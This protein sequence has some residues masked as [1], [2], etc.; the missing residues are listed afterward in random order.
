MRE[1]RWILAHGLRLET[2]RKCMVQEH[3]A[4]GL[5]VPCQEAVKEENC[6]LACFYVFIKYWTPVQRI[7]LHLNAIGNTIKDMPKALFEEILNPVLLG[8]TI[9]HKEPSWLKRGGHCENHSTHNHI[10]SCGRHHKME[11]RNMTTHSMQEKCNYEEKYFSL[12]CN[13]FFQNTMFSRIFH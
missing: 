6:W 7:V 2:V 10:L 4:V 5:I 11:I 9:Q 12:Y 1:E 13:Y 3:D 8:V